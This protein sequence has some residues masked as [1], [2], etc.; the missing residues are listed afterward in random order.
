MRVL[1]FYQAR[2]IMQRIL[3]DELISE[4]DYNRTI[5]LLAEQL[6]VDAKTG[7]ALIYY[8][9]ENEKNFSR[10]AKNATRFLQT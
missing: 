3:K 6:E 5:M 2:Q 7:S 1:K 8:Y 9:L 10:T 4:D